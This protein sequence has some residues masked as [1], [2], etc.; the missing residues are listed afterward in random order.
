[1]DHERLALLALH[2]IPGVGSYTIRQLISYCGSAESI[3]QSPKNKLLKVPGVGKSIADA[4]GT[5][6]K[7]FDQA[8]A[9]LERVEKRKVKLL[10]HMDDE[11]P[12]RL[13]QIPDAPSLLY[14][15]GNA[16]LNNIKTVAIVGTRKATSYGRGVTQDFVAGLSKHSPLIISGMA[17]GIDAEAHRASLKHGLSTIAVMA[18]G[19]EYI[20][21]AEHRGLSREIRNQGGL[22]TE[23]GI[24]TIPDAS[25]FPARNRIIAGMSDV[26]L[27]IE[28][29]ERG[30][31]LITAAIANDYDRE[32]M[33]VP[34][35]LNN[36]Y[37]QGCHQ[38][39]RRNRAHILT[40]VKDIEYL[41]NWDQQ[42][43][44]PE[45]I[46]DLL[47]EERAIVDEFRNKS[48]TL[49][50]DKLSWAIGRTVGQT[51]SLLLQLEFKGLVRALP[52]KMFQLVG[53]V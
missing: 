10:F 49:H 25:R 44:Q 31:A 37:S 34:G 48:T 47:P 22:L 8:E 15:Q 41:M 50:L 9:E 17:Y 16:P 33:A 43:K 19:I 13:R 35:N 52:G 24:D 6:K 51:A 26:V 3:F 38:L 30:G 23:N 21:P 46:F 29:A 7:F 53:Q 32:V 40:S 11:F 14:Y 27:V 4:I 39:I 45:E 1:M 18:G 5:G 36:L 20:Y 12:H 2:L 42:A 28:A